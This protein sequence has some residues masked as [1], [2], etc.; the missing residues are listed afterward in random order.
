MDV[1]LH[2][3]DLEAYGDV[4][5]L[6]CLRFYP[7]TASAHGGPARAPLAGEPRE[8]GVRRQRDGRRRDQR[9]AR[10]LPAAG[11]DDGGD[12]RPREPARGHASARSRRR[13]ATRSAAAGRQTAIDSLERQVTRA[14]GA[15]AQVLH[16]ERQLV[17][18]RRDRR[19]TRCSQEAQRLGLALINVH[20]GFPALLGPG[21]EEYVRSRDLPQA[22]RD[23]PGA[24]L[25]RLPLGLLPGRGH[26][27]S[28]SAS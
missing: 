12:A 5:E 19:P 18:R 10:R 28:S 26:R 3:V 14:R 17:A 2:H 4:P 11:R 20:K 13:C 21:A 22:L 8:G 24:A 16:G 6:G 1:Q 25:R 23:L 7:P 15:R 9:R 27:A